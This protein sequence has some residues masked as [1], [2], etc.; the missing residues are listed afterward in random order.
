MRTGAS[1]SK[2][3]RLFP[4]GSPAAGVG[5]ITISQE[6]RGRWRVTGSTTIT[7]TN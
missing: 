1:K 5:H 2:A 6:V 3:F 4:G 7:V